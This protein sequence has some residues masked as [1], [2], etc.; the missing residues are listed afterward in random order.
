MGKEIKGT[1]PILL[2]AKTAVEPFV[3]SEE[4]KALLKGV[5]EGR[6]W[7]KISGHQEGQK[8]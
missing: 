2:G 3:G 6:Q 8:V 4:V 1:S 5:K 7:K